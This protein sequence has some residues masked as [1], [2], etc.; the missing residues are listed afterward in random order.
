M[1]PSPFSLPTGESS[2]K[3]RCLV[4]S[5]PEGSFD[6]AV[7]R[8]CWPRDSG[9]LGRGSGCRV[10][11]A[12]WPGLCGVEAG[13]GG[14]SVGAARIAE[15]WGPRLRSQSPAG[16]SLFAARSRAREHQLL[17]RVWEPGG[18]WPRAR[19]AFPSRAVGRV[20]RA[21]P[22]QEG[23][24]R[25]DSPVYTRERGQVRARAKVRP[26]GWQCLAVWLWT[27]GLG[28]QRLRTVGRG[29]KGLVPPL[30][31][32]RVTLVRSTPST[33][34]VVLSAARAS[35]LHPLRQPRRA[36]TTG[37]RSR[38]PSRGLP[39]AWVPGRFPGLVGPGGHWACVRSPQGSGRRRNETRKPETF[40]PARTVL[41]SGSWFCFINPRPRT[42]VQ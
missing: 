3:A 40:C 39:L 37:A 11:G 33:P 27:C 31:T 19:V 15:S 20:R 8:P 30:L 4:P 14:G 22:R 35:E 38:A 26:R 6:R 23:G 28:S 29:R 16:S 32:E 24:P 10:P 21:G 12:P 17:G 41:P 1:A 13:P 42:F 34:S 36:G 18:G 25:V 2:R 9:A 7:G 5:R